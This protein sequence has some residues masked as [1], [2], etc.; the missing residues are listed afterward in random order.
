M[1]CVPELGDRLEL[2]IHVNTGDSTLVLINVQNLDRGMDMLF[3]P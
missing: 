3:N 1:N 2:Y